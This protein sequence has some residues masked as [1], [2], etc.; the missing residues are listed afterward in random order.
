[1]ESSRVFREI[2]TKETAGKMEL[3]IELSVIYCDVRS[4]TGNDCDMRCG[5][6]FISRISAY[7]RYAVF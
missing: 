2:V 6:Y 4:D 1:M 7:I 5:T 3:R